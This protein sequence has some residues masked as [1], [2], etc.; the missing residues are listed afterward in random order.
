MAHRPP[1]IGRFSRQTGCFLPLISEAQ[2]GLKTMNPTVIST[3][4]RENAPDAPRVSE[5]RSSRPALCGQGSAARWRRVSRGR[6]LPTRARASRSIKVVGEVEVRLGH[7]VGACRRDRTPRRTDH[8]HA[9]PVPTEPCTRLSQSPRRRRGL[10]R[11]VTSLLA[12]APPALALALAPRRLVPLS[13]TPRAPARPRT[14]ASPSASWRCRR[15]R[16]RPPP[17]HRP[18]PPP[19]RLRAGSA[20][21]CPTLLRPSTTMSCSSSWTSAPRLAVA[22][23]CARRSTAA[24]VQRRHAGELRPAPE[25]LAVRTRALPGQQ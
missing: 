2:I 24:R 4:S 12:R 17:P 25:E 7:E 20:L 22:R 8:Q 23:P 15:W 3:K 9:L 6:R 5:A 18:P 14:R 1:G 13:L 16:R 10:R 11:H 21:C 19:P